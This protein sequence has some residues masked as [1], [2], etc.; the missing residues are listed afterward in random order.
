MSETCKA[1]GAILVQ[2]YEG[3]Q[4]FVFVEHGKPGTVRH[5]FSVRKSE[6]GQWEQAG[7][8]SSYDGNAATAEEI[9]AAFLPWD[10]SLLSTLRYGAECPSCGRDNSEYGNICT[11]DD[12]PANGVF[13]NKG[14]ADER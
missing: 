9:V 12:C 10:A 11:S 7:V 14:G 1:R 5:V 8:V 6:S 13:A 3:K 4:H 2:R